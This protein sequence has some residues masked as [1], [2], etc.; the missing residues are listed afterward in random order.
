MLLKGIITC[1]KVPEHSHINLVD[2]NRLCICT[3][4]KMQPEVGGVRAHLTDTWS[5]L[6][7]L[8]FCSTGLNED[9]VFCF[10]GHVIRF[11]NTLCFPQ[12]SSHYKLRF[13]MGMDLFISLIH[14]SKH[15]RETPPPC[16]SFL[17]APFL[18]SEKGMKNSLEG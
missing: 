17:G 1:P 7:C 11:L 8:Y 4:C 6:E 2:I 14:G 15:S 9:T 13:C 12:T 3:G 5:T 10:Y 18:I 16:S